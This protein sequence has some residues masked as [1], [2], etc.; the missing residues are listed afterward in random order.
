MCRLWCWKLQEFS[1]RGLN[2]HHVPRWNHF[3]KWFSIHLRQLR[4][5]KVPH[6]YWR[7]SISRLCI[8]RSWEV[9]WQYWRH[10][11]FRVR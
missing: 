5:W 3:F 6:D 8:V 2:M 10:F 1:F 11:S 7:N 4:S 9:L